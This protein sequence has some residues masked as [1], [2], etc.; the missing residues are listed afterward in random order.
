MQE[1]FEKRLGTHG[2]SVK[3]LSVLAAKR[4]SPSLPA[5]SALPV[6]AQAASAKA[7]AAAIHAFILMRIPLFVSY[8]RFAAR[9]RVNTGCLRFGEFLVAHQVIADMVV[10]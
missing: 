9:G 1:L 2:L 8:L 7:L 4:F 5:V 3:S 10:A 6:V